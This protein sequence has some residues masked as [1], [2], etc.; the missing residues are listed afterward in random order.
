MNSIQ[1]TKYQAQDEEEEN[2]RNST[3]QG[4]A[5]V[6]ENQMRRARH[7]VDSESGLSISASRGRLPSNDHIDRKDITLTS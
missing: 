4:A 6:E 3:L 7:R 1:I 2:K 5:A